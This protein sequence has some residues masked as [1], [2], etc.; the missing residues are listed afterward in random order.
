MMT[1]NY[2][3][4]TDILSNMP[5]A[6]G[7]TLGLLYLMHLLIYVEEVLI[8][9]DA[10]KVVPVVMEFEEIATIPPSPPKKVDDP[11]P[12]PPTLVEVEKVTPEIK[13]TGIIPTFTRE[14]GGGPKIGLVGGGQLLPYLRV[15]P[16]YPSRA[17]ARGQEGFVDV[18]FDVSE[19]GATGN[20]QVLYSEPS[21]VF[22]RATLRAVSQ[23]KYKPNY[24]DGVPVRTS[25]LKER[26]RFTI[27]R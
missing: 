24:V 14:W 15:Q 17:L 9:E 16:R 21:G 25:G 22:D 23:W 10:P 1:L 6:C 11:L 26:I 4:Y 8:E 13:S 5:A 12:Q 19:Y 3:P 18:M 2:K 7:V 20:A 27:E